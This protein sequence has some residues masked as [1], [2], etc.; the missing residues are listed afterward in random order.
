VQQQLEKCEERIRDL[1]HWDQ[2][3]STMKALAAFSVGRVVSAS[4][5]D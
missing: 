2:L 5:L 4:I 1:L 3:I